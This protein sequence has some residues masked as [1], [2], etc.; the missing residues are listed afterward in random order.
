MYKNQKGYVKVHLHQL[1]LRT[2]NIDIFLLTFYSIVQS[3]HYRSLFEMYEN[4]RCI[5]TR[6]YH[7]MTIYCLFYKEMHYLNSAILKVHI[8]INLWEQKPSGTLHYSKRGTMGNLGIHTCVF[9]MS[10][11]MKNSLQNPKTQICDVI[12]YNVWSFSKNNELRK[13][14]KMT[15][16]TPRGMFGGN[17]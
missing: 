16:R 10:V 5:I 9:K 12:W 4:A 13:I 15:L 14:L 2:I 7:K 11:N 17:G 8:W 6:K 3:I 1:L